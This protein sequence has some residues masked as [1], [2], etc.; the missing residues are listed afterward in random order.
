MPT[1]IGR[2]RRQYVI[3]IR[4]EYT[5]CRKYNPDTGNTEA[6]ACKDAWSL[7]DNNKDARLVEQEDRSY[8]TIRLGNDFFELRRPSNDG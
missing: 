2:N 8:Y 6:A 3:N 5:D 4:D 1:T 7:L